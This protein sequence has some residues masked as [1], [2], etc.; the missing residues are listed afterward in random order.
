M[1]YIFDLTHIKEDMWGVV[2]KTL[3]FGGTILVLNKYGVLY[4]TVKEIFIY[5]YLQYGVFGVI[6]IHNKIID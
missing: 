1:I 5:Q 6:V 4:I 2:N 3:L